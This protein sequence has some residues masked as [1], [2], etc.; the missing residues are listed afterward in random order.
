ME[1]KDDMRQL[2][3]NLMKVSENA[4]LVLNLKK[5]KIMTT[6]ITGEFALGRTK[7][8]LTDC[9]IFLGSMISRDGYD[10]N[11]IN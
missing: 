2:L 10:S 4:G 11:E 1:D 5:T 6:G 8:K 9:Y 3:T 7:V